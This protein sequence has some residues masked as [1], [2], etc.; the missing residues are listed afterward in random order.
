[1]DRLDGSYSV[2]VTGSGPG[3]V[4][5][6]GYD[7]GTGNSAR[8][9]NL[10]ARNRA[11]SGADILIAGFSIAGSG[12]RRVLIRA[13]GPALS[14][15]GVSAVLIDPKLE[16]FDGAAKVSENDNWGPEL[17]ETFAAVG[18]FPL[19][20]A[21]KDSAVIV[22]LDAGRSYTVQVSGVN[23]ATGEALVELYEVP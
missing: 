9:I 12:K 22:S 4:L 10:S 17:T 6:E 18:A 13:V 20:V 2:R 16:L 19:A 5:V 8:L 3:V 11:G 14:N 1:M 23:G 15:F 7:A 21:S